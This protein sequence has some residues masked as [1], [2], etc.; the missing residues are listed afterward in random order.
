MR[1]PCIARVS[2]FVVYLSTF[3]RQ[4][5]I[6]AAWSLHDSTLLTKEDGTGQMPPLLMGPY[7]GGSNKPRRNLTP[8]R[9]KKEVSN[10]SASCEHLMA[11]ADVSGRKLT[12][13]ETLLIEY[14]CLEVLK[15]VVKR[16][17][18]Q[19]QQEGSPGSSQHPNVLPSDSK[20]LAVSLSGIA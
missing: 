5:A 15:K 18:S 9:S 1:I 20:H 17:P 10:F 2:Y 11:E 14:Y 3:K 16:P 4:V 8:M 12:Q 13:E 6:A 19:R 7:S